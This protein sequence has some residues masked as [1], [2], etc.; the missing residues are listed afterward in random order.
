MV[1]L[2]L[3]LPFDKTNWER[4]IAMKPAFVAGFGPITRD[5]DTSTRSGARRQGIALEES[6]TGY[7]TTHDLGV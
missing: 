1:Y 4:I 5:S 2:A 6:D 3:A 7:F